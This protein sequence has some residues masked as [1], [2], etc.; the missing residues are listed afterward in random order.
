MSVSTRIGTVDE[1]RPATTIHLKPDH[2]RDSGPE[3]YNQFEGQLNMPAPN[4]SLTQLDGLGQSW[5][6]RFCWVGNLNDIHESIEY[7]ARAFN[8]T[9]SD[10]P[11]LPD[12][13]ASLGSS[14]YTRFQCLDELNDIEKSNEFETRALNLTP[15]DHPDLPDCLAS[16]GS[17]YR[18]RFQLLGSPD[19]LN[20]AIRSFTP[21][22][23]LFPDD[24]PSLP[25]RHHGLARVYF[26]GFQATGNSSTLQQS[27]NS[28]R[29]ASYT[30]TGAPR[31]RF[32]HALD[33]ATLA[34]RNS[35][36][37]CIE[38]YQTAIDLLP[39]F[40]CR[41]SGGQGCLGCH[42][43]LGVPLTLTWLEYARCVIWNQSLM[44]RSPLDQLQSSHPDLAARLYTVSRQL[45]DA[46]SDSDSS[47]RQ[48]F[49]PD[50]STVTPEHD[51][52]SQAQAL[53]GFENL[54]RPVHANDLIR[55]ARHGPI[56]VLNCH[57]D[58][59]A[60]LIVVPGR[61]T[62]DHLPLPDCS[63]KKMKE[64]HSALVTSLRSKGI[65]ERGFKHLQHPGQKDK[66]QS[67]LLTVW[68]TIVKPVLDFLG[69]TSGAPT[70]SLPHITWCP[71]GPLSFLP[72]HAAGNYDQP[73]SRVFDY[74]ISSYTP[75]LTA[76]LSCKPST[77][78]R[79]SRVLAIG[80]ART[81]GRSPLPGTTTELECVRAYTHN[82]IEHSQ[83]IDDQATTAAVLDAME[84]H[85]WNVQD[86]TK[87]G[88][89][90]HEGALDLASINRRSFKSKG[91]AFLLACQTATGDESLPDKAIHLASG[92]L[93]AEYA[94]VI[95]TMWSVSDSDAPFVA[96][97][98]YAELM[99]DGKVGNGEGGR[100]LHHGIEALREKV[101]E[102]NFGRW[103]PYIHIGS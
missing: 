102:K 24:H 33:W 31:A 79:T 65:R 68:T 67:M 56:V 44:L 81:P 59:C 93:T 2:I 74:A 39:Q 35:P 4:D 63:E 19:D 71:T 78:S 15:N 1:S 92:M 97:K 18:S 11:D 87:S 90:L 80:Q 7:G 89:F 99:K 54:L 3:Q 66:V 5:L 88:F 60:A 50:S 12:R 82:K 42:S 69:Y 25:I 53:S 62:I 49:S 32:E 100:A 10:D 41:G 27:L 91:L 57:Q 48:A 52:L 95:E 20:S 40:I 73:Q 14:Y 17:S 45:H 28:F 29:L 84:H 23:N 21:A 76:L 51:L 16:L 38:A 9:P 64:A 70:T 22:C 34:S 94:S 26:S 55:A 8:L 86:P 13:L 58:H 83:L 101:G 103:V 37:N 43:V 61:E 98:V 36:L 46:A 6:D 72:L 77:L 47:I 30:P 96:D 85:D 75:A